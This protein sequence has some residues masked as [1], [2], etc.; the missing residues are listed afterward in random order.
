MKVDV[1]VNVILGIQRTTS[2]LV[3]G[4]TVVSSASQIGVKMLRKKIAKAA[5]N[6]T[7]PHVVK[8]Y[9]E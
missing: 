9:C 4:H 2:G 5:Q 3:L 1:V 8:S 7:P 6:K